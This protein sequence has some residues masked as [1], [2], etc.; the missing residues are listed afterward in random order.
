MRAR[1]AAV[2]AG[3]VV[4]VV[5]GVAVAGVLRDR[6]EIP[7]DDLFGDDPTGSPSA[8]ASPTQ[9]P[10]P[11]P[12]ADVTGPLNILLVG[13]DTR[14]DQPSWRPNADSVLILHVNESLR[15]AFIFSL[16]RDLLVNVPAFEPAGWGGG[17]TKLTH[18]M[19]YGSVVPGRQRP[20]PAQGFQ[21]LAR[22][23]RRITGIERFDAG[24]V[25]NFRGMVRLVDAL[26]GVEM[27]VPE[28]VASLHKQPDGSG[29]VLVGGTFTGPQKVYPVG[30]QTFEGWEA[31]DYS[32]QRYGVD[33]G[34]Y[35]RQ[36]NQRRL[37]RAIVNEVL[38][39]DL[40][41]DPVRMDRVLRALGDTLVFDGRGHSAIDFA[42][43]LRRLSARTITSVNLPGESVF[44]G[45]YQG[46]R[47]Q[48]VADDFFEAVREQRVSRFLDSHP[49]LVD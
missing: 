5:G 41:T 49:R 45:G 44:N 34:D 4:L 23:V 42:Y 24:A 27:Y 9:S 40:Q 16:P 21:L 1:L 17:T 36:R 19:S 35:G 6:Y 2:V 15:Q 39:Q 48:P 37:I 28:R 38:S 14:L 46:E 11:E 29:R 8:S 12:G 22:T 43:A 31:L 26:G 7:S 20:D 18:A 13:V 47:L 25:L 33:D 30:R 3:L 10:T 32:R